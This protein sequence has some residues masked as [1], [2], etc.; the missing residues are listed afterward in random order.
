MAESSHQNGIRIRDLLATP[1]LELELLAGEGGLDRTVTWAHV[2]E[3]QEPEAWL[4][5]GELLICNGLGLSRE[6]AGQR[7]FIARLAARGVSGLAIG[8]LGPP[9][10]DDFFALANELDFPVMRVPKPVPFMS[11]SRLVADYSQQGAQRRSATHL[12][13][14]DTLREGCEAAD[15][16]KILEKLEAISGYELYVCTPFRQPLLPG[17]AEPPMSMAEPLESVRQEQASRRSHTIPGGYIVPI[18]VAD[19]NAGF[20]IALEDERRE[21]AGLGAIRHMGTISALLIANLYRKREAERRH[22][23]E[24][25]NAIL[26]SNT[27]E[28]T[29]RALKGTG[30]GG[31]ALA[32]ARLSAEPAVIDEVHHRVCD[33]GVPHLLAS[34]GTDLLAMEDARGVLP[35]LIGDLE[36]VVGVSSNFTPRQ[37][38]AR[39]RVEAERALDRTLARRA[40]PGTVA[41][42]SPADS[43]LDWLPGDAAALRALGSDVLEPLREYDREHGTAMLESL[44]VYFA[45]ERRLSEAARALFVHKHTLAYRLKRVAEI[46]GRDLNRLNDVCVLYLALQATNAIS[47]GDDVAQRFPG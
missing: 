41:S 36:I 1:N 38:W 10:R 33:L 9:E 26:A 29:S 35:D 6:A 11:I 12:R 39:A 25:L 46:T 19:R 37:S 17:L 27:P 30:L 34:E 13:L 21:P 24:L 28:A 7:E 4:E 44:E 32:L 45:H 43:P 14:F 16:P 15:A 20:L 23:A 5:G 2:S 8:S 40:A 31:G 3:L 47:A 22:G 42:Y 18:P